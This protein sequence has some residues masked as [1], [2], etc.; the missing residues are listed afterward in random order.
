MGSFL[1]ILCSMDAC[2]LKGH[3][4]HVNAPIHFL[5]VSPNTNG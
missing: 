4:A 5:N 1:C 2:L 3:V